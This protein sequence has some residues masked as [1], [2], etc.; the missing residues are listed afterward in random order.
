MVGWGLLKDGWEPAW[1]LG[2]TF[3]K[4]VLYPRLYPR[5]AFDTPFFDL[6][7]RFAEWLQSPAPGY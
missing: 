1:M 3:S 7:R 4:P 5:F 2:F 6:F